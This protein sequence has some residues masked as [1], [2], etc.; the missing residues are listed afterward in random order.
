MLIFSNLQS[1]LYK[2]N[3]DFYLDLDFFYYLQYLA[4]NFNSLFSMV[5]IFTYVYWQCYKS[6]YLLPLIL[7]FCSLFGQAELICLC[8]KSSPI[9]CLNPLTS[10]LLL[11][12]IKPT[13]LHSNNL[14]VVFLLELFCEINLAVYK[15]EVHGCM[16]SFYFLDTCY[17]CSIFTNNLIEELC[18][19]VQKNCAIVNTG[20]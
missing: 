20:A 16:H 11:L 17:M 6:V 10:M 9:C 3:I 14:R 18:I 13:R 15:S 5:L 2:C 4:I 7:S 12:D 19:H 1:H 8:Q